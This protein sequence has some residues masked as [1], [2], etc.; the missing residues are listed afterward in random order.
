MKKYFIGLLL[1]LTSSFVIFA[2]SYAKPGVNL[3]L[4]PS[5]H[6]NNTSSERLSWISRAAL[7]FYFDLNIWRKADAGYV[8]IFAKDGKVIHATAKGMADIDNRVAMNTETRF[9]IASM[10]K[11]ITAIATL[12]L[13]EEGKLSL[14]DPI[15]KFIPLAK[16]IRVAVPG[17]QM[18]EGN[19]VTE[20]LELSL[21]HI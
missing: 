15:E 10:T 20:P 4:I 11:P 3:P 2:I 19:I 13:I 6:L 12:I 1:I 16:K 8:A 18:F 14:Y 17:E 5:A 7:D 9:R 21:I